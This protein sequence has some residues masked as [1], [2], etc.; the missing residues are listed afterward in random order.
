MTDASFQD[1]KDADRPLRLAAESADDLGVASSLVQDAVG[2]TRD[3]SWMPGR[4][5][6]AVL[7]NRFRWEDQEAAKRDGR[8]FE[9]V[10]SAL[11]FDDVIRVQSQGLPPDDGETVFSVLAIAFEP[12]EDGA[13]RIELTLAGDGAL[14]MDVECINMRL[15]DLTKPWETG[16]MPDHGT[17]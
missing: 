5:R 6:L 11:V 7:I 16:N 4:R 15:A 3:V 2:V 1:G 14:A 10:R 8:P 12:G 13:G 17:D 9:R